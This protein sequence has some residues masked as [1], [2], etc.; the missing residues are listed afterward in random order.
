MGGKLTLVLLIL[1][2]GCSWGGRTKD[3]PSCPIVEPVI[4]PEYPKAQA[5]PAPE[6]TELLDIKNQCF[7]SL[8]ER[9]AVVDNLHHQIMGLHD[10][11]GYAKSD[12]EE[13]QTRYHEK[14]CSC[15]D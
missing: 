8:Q 5:T 3:I 15:E 7:R 6:I 11:V 14:T 4:C 10:E 9:E 13:W 12:A 1:V 2:S